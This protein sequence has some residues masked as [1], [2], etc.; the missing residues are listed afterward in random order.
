M[1][2]SPVDLDVV[3]VH[4]AVPGSTLAP[5]C[6]QMRDSPS[7]NALPGEK[8]DFDSAWFS[9]LPWTGVKGIV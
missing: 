6:L 1:V 3:A 7:S 4:A 5:E 8:A 9:Q 2:E